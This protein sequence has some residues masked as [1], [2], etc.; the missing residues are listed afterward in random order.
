V[1]GKQIA[2][3]RDV[4]VV[5]LAACT[6]ESVQALNQCWVSAVTRRSPLIAMHGHREALGENATA[7]ALDLTMTDPQQLSG[8]SSGEFACD[9]LGQNLGATLLGCAQS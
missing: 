8:V 1:T 4:E 9:E 5:I 6:A 2:E 3:M 7:Q